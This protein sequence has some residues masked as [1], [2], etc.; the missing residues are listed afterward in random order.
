MGGNPVRSNQADAATEPEAMRSCSWVTISTRSLWL[1]LIRHA[2]PDISWPPDLGHFSWH[3]LSGWHRQGGCITAA[4]SV[5]HQ[6]ESALWLCPATSSA[7]TELTAVS[8]TSVISGSGSA[9]FQHWATCVSLRAV[10][11]WVTADNYA[12]G[13]NFLQSIINKFVLT[14]SL[15]S[16]DVFTSFW[17][18]RSLLPILILLEHSRWS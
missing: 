6:P 8:P 12:F 11:H 15:E 9:G 5:Y 1:K 3:A 18:R 17:V 16:K 13:S 10:R 4:T 7:V 2:L 14:Q